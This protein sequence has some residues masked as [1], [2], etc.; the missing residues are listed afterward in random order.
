MRM[1]LALILAVVCLG[2]AYASLGYS[3]C[4][5]DQD[6]VICDL[7]KNVA[8][9]ERLLNS[10]RAKYEKLI[11]RK[12]QLLD[13]IEQEKLKLEQKQ[14][15]PVQRKVEKKQ[16]CSDLLPGK[17]VDICKLD[18]DSQIELILESKNKTPD[19]RDINYLDLLIKKQKEL[20]AAIIQ[21]EI[22]IAEEEKTLEQLKES[23][24]LSPN[25]P[26]L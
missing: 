19:N 7:E 3:S 22:N 16:E 5:Q 20:C 21:L 18:R 12:K 4:E 1:A 26:K 25:S 11:S 23:R 6:P 15:G 13:W 9:Q 8:Q 17:K 24:K 2:P 10:L 14:A